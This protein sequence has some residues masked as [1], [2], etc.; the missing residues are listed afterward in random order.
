MVLFKENY[1]NTYSQVYLLNRK[2][3]Y[4]G[5]YLQYKKNALI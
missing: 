5:I 4:N 2:N 1:C 3:K